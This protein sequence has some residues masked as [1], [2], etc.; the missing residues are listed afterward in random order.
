MV[1]DLN[2]ISRSSSGA[3]GLCSDLPDMEAD[4][5]CSSWS[6]EVLAK[7]L[8]RLCGLHASYKSTTRAMSSGY[9]QSNSP[10]TNEGTGATLV[11]QTIVYEVQAEERGRKRK[12]TEIQQQKREKD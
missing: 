7:A 8:D 4:L 1:L 5:A 10:H 2:D 3:M 9:G 12:K 6:E 11:P